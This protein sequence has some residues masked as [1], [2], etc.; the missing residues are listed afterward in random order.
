MIR[1]VFLGQAPA[2]LAQEG[3]EDRPALKPWDVL[4]ARGG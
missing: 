1:K 3:F 2:L 4:I